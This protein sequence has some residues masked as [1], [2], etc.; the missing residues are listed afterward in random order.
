MTADGSA[1]RHPVEVLLERAEQDPEL[2]AYVASTREWIPALVAVMAPAEGAKL[3]RG[4]TPA[5]A[6]DQVAGLLDR[7]AEHWTEAKRTAGVRT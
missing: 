5:I 4:E 2:A 7:V 6:F 3:A 1:G